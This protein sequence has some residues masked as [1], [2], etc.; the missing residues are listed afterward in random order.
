MM[1]DAPRIRPLSEAAANRIAAGEVIERPAAAVKELVENALDA[2]A[3]RIDIAIAEG[4]VRLIRVADD[5]E[6]MSAAE[7]PLALM[8]H[9]TSKTD[10]ADLLDIRSFGFRGEALPS[11]AAVARLSIT[12][13]RAGSGEAYRITAEAGRVGPVGPAARAAGTEIVLRDLFFATPARLKFLRAERTERLEVAETVKRLAM[14]AP[15]VAITLRD[16]TGEGEGRVLFDAPAEQGTE[17]EARR[18]RLRRVMGAAFADSAIDVEAER[19]GL[20][21]TGLAGLP[22]A[23]RNGAVAQHLFVNGRPVRDRLLLGALRAAYGDLIPRDRRAAAALYLACDPRR[24]DVNVHPAKTEVRFREP[25]LV[26]GL[27]VAALRHALADRGHRADTALTDFALGAARA[28]AATG[29]T[30]PPRPALALREAAAAWQAPPSPALTG[31][32]SAPAAP[33]PAA[34]DAAHPGPLGT[35]RALLH[36][37]YILSQ[38]ADGVILVDMHAAHERLVYERLK[39]AMAA[40]PVPAQALL[41]PE[42]VEL[43]REDSERLLAHAADLE[44][45][46]LTL[47]PFGPGTLAV[48]ATPAPLGACDAAALL[49][50]IADEIAEMGNADTLRAR[51]D[52]VL[53]RIAC[54]GSVRSG[55]RLSLPEMDAL[56]RDIERTPAA[57]SCNHGRP[58]WVALGLA[59]LERLFGRR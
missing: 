55:R 12:S 50:D 20:V 38:S 10:G 1:D 51:L 6:G 15:H 27:I 36:D 14:A 5:G 44:P 35:A 46:G 45:L 11:M 19:D 18:A 17:S 21:L 8:R 26:R 40:G 31:G 37:T 54:H 23:A 53:S 39:A 52:A 34:A 28:H 48:R 58:T 43:G 30:P 42:I 57:Q 22:S 49:R 24:V 2:G 29:W 41:I 3:T 47:E 33:A 16:V 25:G 59:D 9:A 7:L 4:G 13:H 56:L 32:W